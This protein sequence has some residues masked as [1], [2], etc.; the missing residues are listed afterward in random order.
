ME[1]L[2]DEGPWITKRQTDVEPVK[3]DTDARE[4][5]DHIE[6]LDD[7]RYILLRKIPLRVDRDEE[8]CWTAFIEGSTIGMP[9]DTREQAV[10]ELRGAMLDIYDEYSDDPEILGPGP[11]REWAVLQ[12][13]IRHR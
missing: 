13:Y 7:S 4:Y 12:R 10:E 6:N 9:G 8:G 1:A 11:V 3:W 2:P 5:H